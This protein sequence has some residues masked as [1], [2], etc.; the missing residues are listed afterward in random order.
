VCWLL[1]LYTRCAP[2]VTAWVCALALAGS[3]ASCGGW[4]SSTWFWKKSR[5]I[6]GVRGPGGG[7]Q[8]RGARQPRSVERFLNTAADTCEHIKKPLTLEI[9]YGSTMADVRSVVEETSGLSMEGFCFTSLLTVDV[10]EECTVYADHEMGEDRPDNWRLESL[11]FP[12]ILALAIE[13]AVGLVVKTL[14]GKFIDLRMLTEDIIETVELRIQQQEGMVCR[15]RSDQH[16]ALF[17]NLLPSYFLHRLNLVQMS[18]FKVKAQPSS[19]ASTPKTASPLA[20]VQ[21]GASSRRS[22]PT[23]AGGLNKC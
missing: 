3:Q 7:R 9:S 1:V 20:W 2:A 19:C 18:R 12:I 23:R 22:T 21:R 17:P 5:Y 11:R 4:S 16:L 14:T 8:T 10:A 6:R 13:D 15:T